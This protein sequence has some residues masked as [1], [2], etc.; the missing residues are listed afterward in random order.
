[1]IQDA[2]LEFQKSEDTLTSEESKKEAINI[3][4]V[5]QKNLVQWNPNENLTEEE[6]AG[7]E[8]EEQA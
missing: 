4:N 3:I 7:E 2:I 5:M 8:E 6:D 1:M